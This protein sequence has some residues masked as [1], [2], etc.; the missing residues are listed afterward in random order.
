MA[1]EKTSGR[2]GHRF[3]ILTSLAVFFVVLA[4]ALGLGLGLGLKHHHNRSSSNNSN[5]NSS[6]LQT[7]SPQASNAFVVGSILGQPPQERRYN[8]TINFANGAPDGVNKTMLVVN[9]A[10]PLLVILCAPRGLA[11]FYVTASGVAHMHHDL[12]G[13]SK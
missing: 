2:T 5:S 10:H 11:D 8:F 13:K 3:W 7:L 9:G 4:L 6:E 12:P 1:T